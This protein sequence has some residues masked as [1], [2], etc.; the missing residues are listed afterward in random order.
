M[1]SAA[2]AELPDAL[3]LTDDA[4]TARSA[5]TG[6]VF[7]ITSQEIKR[8][9]DLRVPLPRLSYAE[10]MQQRWQRLGAIDLRQRSSARSG[11]PLLSSFDAVIAP[12]LW[13][14]EEWDLEF[15]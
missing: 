4:L 15:R 10:R 2:I 8:Y 5:Q 9:R 12:V 11:E 3:P 6:R 1:P 14:K 7:R 13:T